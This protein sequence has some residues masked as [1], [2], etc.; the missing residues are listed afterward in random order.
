MSKDI[1]GP[2]DVCRHEYT[3]K[4]FWYDARNDNSGHD[5]KLCP[6]C[7]YHP[8]YIEQKIEAILNKIEIRARL[9]M[10]SPYS[11]MPQIN[12]SQITDDLVDMILRLSCLA[13]IEQKRPNPFPNKEQMKIKIE[14]ILLENVYLMFRGL[15]SF[16]MTEDANRAIVDYIF[17]G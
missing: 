6:K 1:I 8:G 7:G 17:R 14:Q 10:C 3:Q 9:N 5:I 12:S 15:Q 13:Q 4:K 11:F 16:V 2:C